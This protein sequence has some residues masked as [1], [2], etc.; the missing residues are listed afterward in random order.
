[1]TSYFGLVL[2]SVLFLTSLP[3]AIFA[4]FTTSLAF[5]TL[6]FRALVVY[7]ELAA[8]LLRNQFP[9]KHMSEIVA[10]DRTS[11]LSTSDEK[12]YRQ[13]SRRTSASSGGSMDPKTPEA[14]GLGVYGTGGIERDFEG[15]GG[16]KSDSDDDD[17]PWASISSRLELPAIVDERKRNH[18]RS[19]TSGSL[20]IASMIPRPVRPLAR[21]PSS[22]Q[23]TSNNAGDYFSSRISSKSSSALDAANIGKTL[24]RRKPSTASTYVPEASGRASHNP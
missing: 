15:V 23:A 19:L 1:M 20:S 3:L 8:V 4:A 22:A 7:A 5:S 10:F 16:W 6:F 24:L 14:V 13:K 21:T 11:T 17:V 12:E 2:S 18:R 9:A